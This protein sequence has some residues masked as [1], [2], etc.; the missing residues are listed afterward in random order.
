MLAVAYRALTALL[1]RLGLA[2]APVVSG[3]RV[4]LNTITFGES[5]NVLPSRVVSNTPSDELLRPTVHNRC[6]AIATIG[7]DA[8]SRNSRHDECCPRS[9]PAPLARP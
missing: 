7:D 5:P 2:L 9:F 8:M 4:P 6:A 3:V 1:P